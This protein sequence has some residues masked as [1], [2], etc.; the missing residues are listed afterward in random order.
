MQT[1]TITASLIAIVLSFGLFACGKDSKKKKSPST[2]APNPEVGFNPVDQDPFSPDSSSDNCERSQTDCDA[3]GNVPRLTI[4]S[5]QSW[6]YTDAG[7]TGSRSA[8][9]CVQSL[10]GS[11]GKIDIQLRNMGLRNE[12]DGSGSAARCL[13]QAKVRY[14]KGWAFAIRRVNVKVQSTLRSG[15]TAN[16]KGSYATLGSTSVEVNERISKQGSASTR[17]EK[18]VPNR[19]F[20]WSSCDGESTLSFNTDLE[21]SRGNAGANQLEVSNDSPYQLEIAWARCN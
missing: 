17:I 4:S 11:S 2:S 9:S 10:N 6:R 21:V 16:F 1:K 13:M 7:E 12:S 19:E 18:T 20:A 3:N 14:P 15:T 5:L 8:E